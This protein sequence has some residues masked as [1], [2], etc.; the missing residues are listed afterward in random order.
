MGRFAPRRRRVGRRMKGRPQRRRTAARR[1]DDEQH[2][3]DRGRRTAAV[4]RPEA[5]RIGLLGGFR[6]SIGARVVGEDH[7]RLRKARSLVKLLALSARHR[8]HREE[9]MELLW[10][11]LDPEAASNNLHQILHSARQVFDR[12][13]PAGSAASRYLTLKEEEIVLCPEGPLWVDVEAFEEAAAAARRR[14]LEPAAFRVAIDL[15]PGELLPQDRYEPWVEERRE[16]LEGTYHSLLLELAGLHEERKELEPAIEALERLVAED[17]THEGAHERLMRLYA[18]SGRRREALRQYELLRKALLR[19]LD[20]EPGP[21]TRHL[22]EEILTGSISPTPSPPATDRLPEEPLAP[23]RHNLPASLTSFVGRGR[24]MIEVKRALSM[25][26]LLTLT[27]AGGSGKTRLSLEVARDVASSYADGAW[28]A[29]FAPVSDP[30]LA[31]RTLAAALGVR[32]QPGRPLVVTLS[33]HLRRKKILLVLD[34]CE[35]IIDGVARLAEDLLEVAPGLRILATSREALNVTGEVVWSVPPLSLPDAY[36]EP[37]PES[38]LRS[39]A[40]RLFVDRARFKAPGFR[41]TKANAGAVARAC[42]KLDGIPLAIELATARLGVLAVEQ[43][44]ARL[45]DSLGLLSGSGRSADPRQRTMTATLDWSYRLLEDDERKLLARFSVFAGGATLE[46]V[47]TLCADIGKEGTLDLIS[48]LVEKSMLY[49]EGTDKGVARYRMLE[50]VRQYASRKLEESGEGEEIHARHARYYLR[51]AENLK[52]GLV[53][54]DPAPYLATLEEEFANLR[55]ALSWALDEE[56]GQERAVTGLRLATA[57]A[58]FWDTQGPAEGRRWMEKGL[59]RATSASP[60]VRVEALREAAF[61]ATYQWDPRSVEIL[62]EAFKLYRKLGDRA[63]MLLAVE[64]LGHA[65]AHHSTPEVAEPIVAEVEELLGGSSDPHIRAQFTNF[66]GFAAQV[67]RDHEQTRKLWKEA[68]VLYREVG[69]AGN[70][71][72]CL[73]SLGMV[74]LACRYVDEAA[75]YF[76]EGL[77]MERDVGYKTVVFFYLMGI[78]AVAAHR[79]QARRAAKL[80]GAA[81]KLRE[82]E[83][84]SLNAFASI[85]YDYEGY[86][87]S[88]RDA[89]GDRAF[90]EAW[91]EGRA[92]SLSAAVEYALGDEDASAPGKLHPV[93]GPDLLTRREREVAALIG[94]GYSNRRIAEELGITERTAETHVS[95][96][97]RKLGLRSRTQIAAWAIEQGPLQIDPT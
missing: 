62:Y 48:R 24:E 79:G 38:L 15:Y 97:L 3:D 89:L 16:E 27:G 91:N 94:R 66:L 86:V 95:R 33:E 58:R 36:A 67:E 2:L 63:G 78:S 74:T 54:P 92:L 61:V 47:E 84:I 13:A 8:L 51:L 56:T 42:A 22:Y 20:T 11:G 39:E 17:P 64:N 4:A 77:A 41:L 31:A 55:A 88:V 23:S 1:K 45:E 26:R 21:A 75:A 32:E 72:R 96:V 46:A 69:D 25:T 93:K 80:Y 49:V 18:L 7:W 43:L 71:A 68:L 59:A 14:A 35:H 83:G 34:N 87:A 50:P 60:E 12:A 29:E 40:A 90:E 81:E 10:P 82:S 53:G 37:T 57:L 85:D 70:I 6:V 52:P 65:L 76:E 19:E 28:M 9:A 44:A 30:A 5:V 73:P